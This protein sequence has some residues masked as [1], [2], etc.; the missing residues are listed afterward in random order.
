MVTMIEI[1]EMRGFSKPSQNKLLEFDDMLIYCKKYKKEINR[2]ILIQN[3][4]SH[5][6]IN[7][8]AV[9]YKEKILEV[10][11]MNKPKTSVGGA[12]L[13]MEIGNTL[14]NEVKKKLNVDSFDY[15]GDYKTH[16]DKYIENIRKSFEVDKNGFTPEEYAEIKKDLEKELID[17]RH[18]IECF[19]GFLEK[20]L[21]KKDLEE[22]VTIKK[23][24]NEYI[25]IQN[26]KTKKF[27]KS[28][29]EINYIKEKDVKDLWKILV[30]L[31]DKKKNKTNYTRIISSIII[32]NNIKM[33]IESFNGGKNRAKYY[34]PL[35]YYPLK[36]L[37]HK[38][39]IIHNKRGQVI[40]TKFDKGVEI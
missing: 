22:S 14:L 26:K 38:E 33:R 16:I 29:K 27:N 21:S 7:W 2:T 25:I 28:Y 17:E 32:K 19:C 23:V 39:Y 40:R 8:F 13:A 5:S 4:F 9:N 12:I 34:F 35:Y 37:Q 30:M 1:E 24:D 20:E 36:I 15:N 3:N 18:Y 6:E 11:E 31:T 10:N